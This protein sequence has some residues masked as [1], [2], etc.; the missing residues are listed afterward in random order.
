MGQ[1]TGQ[2]TG[3][4]GVSLI[5][6]I[7]GLT[8]LAIGSLIMSQ[9][10]ISQSQRQKAVEV[11]GNYNIIKMNLQSAVNDPGAVLQSAL[12][13]TTVSSTQTGTPSG[14]GSAQ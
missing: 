4:A 11:R 2:A 1:A 5:E 14:Q 6:A 10:F 8:I 3:H 9:I 12:K 7:I 13:N